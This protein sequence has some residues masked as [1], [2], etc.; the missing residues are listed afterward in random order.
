[1][2]LPENILAKESGPLW[3]YLTANKRN[4][5]SPYGTVNPKDKVSFISN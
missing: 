1:M 3:Y 4:M 2:E 5:Y